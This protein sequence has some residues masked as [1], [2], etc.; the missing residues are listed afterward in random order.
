MS[1]FLSGV[2][3]L[4]WNE[5]ACAA[6]LTPPAPSSVRTT[7]SDPRVPG[8]DRLNSV[9][10]VDMTAPSRGTEFQSSS[11]SRKWR[12]VSLLLAQ[13]TELEGEEEELLGQQ[14]LPLSPVDLVQCLSSEHLDGSSSVPTSA[15]V[16]SSVSYDGGEG[17]DD[18]FLHV[19][20]GNVQKPTPC[21]AAPAADGTCVSPPSAARVLRAEFVS[22]RVRGVEFCAV[23][24]QEPTAFV[25]SGCHWSVRAAVVRFCCM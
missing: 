5:A 3:G 10:D 20:D 15:S 17:S 1:A 13:T 21:L 4:T 16:T 22:C 25:R 9:E 14:M 19:L 12:P 6:V 7:A 11:Q 24:V 8:T 18:G 2:P 23:S